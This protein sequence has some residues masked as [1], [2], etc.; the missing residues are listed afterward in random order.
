MAL[1]LLEEGQARAAAEL[2][3][4]E[5]EAHPRDWTAWQLLGNA[6]DELGDPE[7]A[8]RAYERAL[9]CPDAWEAP[10]HQNRA[11]VLERMDRHEE[12]LHAAERALA[13]PDREPFEAEALNVAVTCLVE[14]GRPDD[15]VELARVMLDRC[16]DRPGGPRAGALHA[17]L[18]WAL[19]MARGDRDAALAELRAASR[20][21][22]QNPRIAELI[23]EMGGDRPSWLPPA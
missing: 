23:E 16:G 14:L 18:A 12:A 6:R 9:T 3:D 10:V 2:L 19:W 8:L 11:V 22:A 4:A 21:D 20:L 7:G 15:A 5:V 1:Q 13:D 17:E